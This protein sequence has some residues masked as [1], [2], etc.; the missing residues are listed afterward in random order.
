MGKRIMNPPSQIPG[1]VVYLVHESNT[2]LG[3]TYRELAGK[4]QELHGLL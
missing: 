2:K 4:R 1:T 3:R